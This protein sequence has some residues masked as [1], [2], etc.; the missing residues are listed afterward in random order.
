[1]GHEE[2]ANI[3]HFTRQISAVSTQQQVSHYDA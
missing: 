1:M 3:G 2:K